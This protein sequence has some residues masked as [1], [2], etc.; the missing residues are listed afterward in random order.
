MKEDTMA[1]QTPRKTKAGTLLPTKILVA[2]VSLAGTVGGWVVLA[3]DAP[4]TANASPAVA[5]VATATPAPAPFFAAP[6]ETRE[7]SDDS[8]T[9]APVPTPAPSTSMQA[10]SAPPVLRRVAPMP[11]A[12]TRSSR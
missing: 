12:I 8:T 1:S 2:A 4:T 6:D 5:I 10:P 7:Q 11:F 3:N 9:A